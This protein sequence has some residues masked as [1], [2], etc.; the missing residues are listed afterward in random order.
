MYRKAAVKGYFYPDNLNELT[1][2][3]SKHAYDGEKIDGIMAIVPHAGYTY[4]GVTAVKTIS[5]LNLKDKILLLGPNH[6]GFGERVALYPEGE[7]ETPFGDVKIS[8]DLNSRLLN[9]S[10]IKE[11]IIAHVREHSL[12]VILPMLKYFK[13]DF[14]FSA[15]TMMPIRYEECINLAQEIYE[16]IKDENITIIV[17]S[18]FNHYENAEITEKKDMLAIKQILNMDSKELYDTVFEKDISMCGIYPAIVG[19]EIA[20]RFGANNS[21]L[22]EHTHSGVVNSDFSQVVGYAG[23]IIY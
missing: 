8:R 14:S 19:I 17:S 18:D 1:S 6:T 22:V 21:L 4:S 16:N 9:I 3:F 2:F 10:Y 11:D 13:K 20:K 12:E 23:I 15:I 7:W 5:R